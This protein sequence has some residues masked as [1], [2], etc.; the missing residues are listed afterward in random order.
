M[1]KSLID[2]IEVIRKTIGDRYA[3]LGGRMVADPKARVE[4]VLNA[5]GMTAVDNS[6]FNSVN[7]IVARITRELEKPE[8][9]GYNGK[10]NDWLIYNGI[11][12]YIHDTDRNSDLPE[13]RSTKDS[14]V[15]E[16]MLVNA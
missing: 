1:L 6:K 16:Y 3:L 4:E 5:V 15:L 10:V 13:V 9:R 7:D 14:N 8:M 12:Q 11:N 2:N